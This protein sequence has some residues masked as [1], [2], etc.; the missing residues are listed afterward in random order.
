MKVGIVS[1]TATYWPLYLMAEEGRAELVELG[2]TE[3]GIG[4]LLRGDVDVACTCPDALIASTARIRIASGLVDR[5]PCSLVAREGIADVASLRGRR[6]AV[7][8]T[9]GSV[10]ILLRALLARHGLSRGDWSEVVVGPTPAQAS[11]LER[12]EADGAMVTVP[13]DERL[14]ASGFRILA[15]AGEDLG[16]CAFTTINVRQGWTASKEWLAFREDL[17]AAFERL[18]GPD[19]RSRELATLARGT[20]GAVRT[21]PRVRYDLTL[22]AGSVRRLIAF[23][24]ADGVAPARELADAFEEAA[25]RVA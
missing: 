20:R 1:R 4:A 11:A 24:G 15:D 25:P 2:S 16:G 19:G 14:V 7:T 13:Y 17:A 5:P 12:G 18:A 6:V 10:S 8:S 3:A 9:R 22:E 21:V 23:M